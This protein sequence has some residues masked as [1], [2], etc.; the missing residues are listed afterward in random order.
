M[1]IF[2]VFM[3][4]L[5]SALALSS[6][7]GGSQKEIFK[8]QRLI[9]LGD[10]ASLI[11]PN[12]S[13]YGLNAL[14]ADKTSFDCAAN[15]LW[16]QTVAAKYGL[17]FQVCNP[18]QVPQPTAYMQ[19]AYGAKVIDVKTQIDT[20]ANTLGL[21]STDMVTLMVGT[22]DL[23]ALLTVTPRGSDAALLDTA[24]Q[25]GQL[26]GDQVLRLTALGPKVVIATL[27]DLSL[28]PLGRQSSAADQ[29]LLKAMSS[30][31]NDQLRVRLAADPNGGGRSGALLPVDDDSVLFTLNANN[32][33]GFTDVTNPA[34]ANVVNGVVTPMNDANL[35]SSCL[36]STAPAGSETW[37][38]AGRV[39]FGPKGQYQLGQRAVQRLNNN[40]L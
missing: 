20:A 6:C 34:C 11:N 27:P 8:P 2:K 37:L 30:R 25:A 28:T 14:T 9:V 13:K 4:S 7:G 24:A 3:L 12:G 21:T 18:T 16:V 36:T 29:A 17:I 40:P 19:A 22:H 31:F 33:F 23:L 35:P 32:A 5:A 1:P 10:E 15:P 39:Q 26:L 38:W